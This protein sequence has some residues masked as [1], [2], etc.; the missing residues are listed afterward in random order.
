MVARSLSIHV[1]DIISKPRLTKMCPV[2]IAGKSMLLFGP[3]L[4]GNVHFH[5]FL[6]RY[7]ELGARQTA[8]EVPKWSQG[9]STWPLV[10]R[11]QHAWGPPRVPGPALSPFRAYWPIKVA[12][13]KPKVVICANAGEY[14]PQLFQMIWGSIH[15]HFRPL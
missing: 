15:D 10:G 6:I 8:Q 12:F 7:L 5:S 2:S 14:S 13:S 11:S 1:F 4:L 3:T 9:G